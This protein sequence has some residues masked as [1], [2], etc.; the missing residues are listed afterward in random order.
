MR[1]PTAARILGTIRRIV[2]SFANAAVNRAGK[3]NPKSKCN[4]GTF[5][6]RFKSAH[7]RRERLH[8]L[9]HPK[10]PSVLDL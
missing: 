5:Q 2:R 10:L 6:S 8:A 1:T 7:G 9:I 4:T 3:N